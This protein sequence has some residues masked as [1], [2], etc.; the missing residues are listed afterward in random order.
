MSTMR[1]FGSSDEHLDVLCR[2]VRE[3][4][5]TE[6]GKMTPAIRAAVRRAIDEAFEVGHNTTTTADWINDL[7]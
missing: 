3:V 6:T 1:K 7:L 2:E 4:V 5:E